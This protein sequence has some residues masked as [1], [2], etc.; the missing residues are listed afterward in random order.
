MNTS[1]VHSAGDHPWVVFISVLDETEE[2]FRSLIDATKSRAEVTAIK[3][4][5]PAFPVIMRDRMHAPNAV[6]F[7]DILRD[8]SLNEP[9]HEEL[10]LE[11]IQ[12]M[13]RGGTCVVVTQPP[14]VISPPQ[15]DYFFHLAGVPWKYSIMWPTTTLLNPSAVSWTTY[16]QL[17]PK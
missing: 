3:G 17:P 10:W 4:A 13:M 15:F 14:L 16:R 7:L 8:A 1:R 5:R 11:G 6:V 9:V 2:K 12:Y